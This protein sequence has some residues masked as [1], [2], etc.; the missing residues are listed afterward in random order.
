MI[1]GLVLL[2]L[3]R[4]S[5]RERT[6]NFHLHMG[7]GTAGLGLLMASYFVLLSAVSRLQDPEKWFRLKNIVILLL[8]WNVIWKF[9]LLRA[10]R[11]R[12]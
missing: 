1:L 8:N 7:L 11:V 9:L 2:G 3:Y 6:N 10:P 4:G 5:F 12:A